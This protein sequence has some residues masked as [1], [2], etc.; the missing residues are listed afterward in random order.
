M[1]TISALEYLENPQAV[2]IEP[3]CAVF[4]NEGWAKHEVLLALRDHALPEDTREFAL[5]KLNGEEAAWRDVIAEL[6][7]ASLFGDGRQ[8]VVIEDADKFVTDH[9]RQL[10]RYVEQPSRSGVLVLMVGQWAATTKLY[11][12]FDKNGLQIRCALGKS[13]AAELRKWIQFLAKRQGLKLAAGAGDLLIEMVGEELGLLHQQLVKLQH[14]AADNRVTP[15]LIRKQCGNW[16]TQSIWNI[17]DAALD[18]RTAEA[19]VELDRLLASGEHP[20]P[21]LAALTSNLRKLVIATNE[22]EIAEQRRQR[23]SL[24]QALRNA[25]VYNVEQNVQRLKNLGRQR[26]KRLPAM[27]QEV[28]LALKDYASREQLGRMQL[29]RLVVWLSAPELAAPRGKKVKTAS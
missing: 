13:P 10:E 24:V 5:S 19:L 9:R 16:R 3:I 12:A 4:G 17:L 1:S 11:K 25:K 2:A 28:D 6:S 23:L 22:I 14:A 29:E 27:L 7:T 26:A 8:L 18:R 21:I 15:E 20:I